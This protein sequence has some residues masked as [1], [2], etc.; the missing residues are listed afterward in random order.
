MFRKFT[1]PW[2]VTGVKE[3]RHNDKINQALETIRIYKIRL[4]TMMGKRKVLRRSMGI[5]N[6][7]V[8]PTP[9]KKTI[10][11]DNKRIKPIGG[12]SRRNR[13]ITTITIKK[14]KLGQPATKISRIR[15]GR[16]LAYETPT[17][18]KKSKCKIIQANETIKER[19]GINTEKKD[20]DPNKDDQGP[21]D[22]MKENK[23]GNA[24]QTRGRD[25][26][27]HQ[28]HLEEPGI[29]TEEKNN[30]AKMTQNNDKEL[31]I[32]TTAN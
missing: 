7:G 30:K 16:A 26:I 25:Q 6:I 31:G 4:T 14:S 15:D 24:R 21:K 22:N 28:H 12:I 3:D 8:G 23:K 10:P 2:T 29:K 27:E 5:L 32:T 18:R 11:S 17:T 9:G 13:R 1:L 19:K 20:R